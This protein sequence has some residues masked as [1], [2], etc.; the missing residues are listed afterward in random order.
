MLPTPIA[1]RVQGLARPGSDGRC[2]VLSALLGAV[3]GLTGP[4]C[5]GR[6]QALTLRLAGCFPAPQRRRAILRRAL[7]GTAHATCYPVL[8]GHG[9]DCQVTY[10][11]AYS[12]TRPRVAT[13]EA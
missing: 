2:H 4:L 13:D 12:E 3:P 1:N 10:A 7:R 6:G 11:A 5:H 9:P 8:T